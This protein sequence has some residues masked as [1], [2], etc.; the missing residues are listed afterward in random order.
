M[1]ISRVNRLL[2]TGIL[3]ILIALASL[4]SSVGKCEEVQDPEKAQKL[5][6]QLGDRSFVVRNQAAEKL[7][8]LGP[9][10]LEAL[11][12][13]KKDPDPEIRKRAQELIAKILSEANQERWQQVMDRPEMAA[14]ITPK[15]AGQVQE[16]AKLS[17]ENWK[18]LWSPKGDGFALLKWKK[19]VELSWAGPPTRPRYTR[20][21]DAAINFTF[22]PSKNLVAYNENGTVY[23]VNPFSNRI[24]NQ[25]ETKRQTKVTFS[26]DGKLM[27][28]GDYSTFAQV[29][30]VPDMKLVHTLPMPGTKGAMRPVF[31]PDGK[32]LAVGNRNDETAI[33]DLATGKRLRMLPRKMTQE[34]AFS[35]DGK[36]LA[37]SY[38]DGQI[39]IWEVA[40]G[41]QVHLFSGQGE[42]IFTLSWSPKGDILASG[43]LN[44]PIGLWHV[45]PKK[46]TLIKKLPGPGRVFAVRFRPDG[47][48]LLTAGN[49]GTHLWWIPAKQK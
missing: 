1:M 26:P 11:K 19:P 5:I 25:K 39:G 13:A 4:G 21:G 6:Q 27:A 31:S 32:L 29:W 10:V 20:I 36:L 46:V 7:L 15:N 44:A 23:L 28:T 16:L 24:L 48:V 2:S 18:A 45:T 34:V 12:A 41:R 47:R 8:K 40:T 30:T 42:E 17:D 37:T 14:L 9:S 22:H 43:G 35:P 3:T 38:V 49:K 33:F